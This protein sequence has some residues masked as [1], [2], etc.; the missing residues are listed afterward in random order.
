VSSRSHKTTS[1]I[2]N[3]LLLRPLPVENP[4]GL[5]QIYTGSSHVSYPNFR[6]FEAQSDVFTGVA[7]HR[8][9]EFNMAEGGVPERVSGEFVSGNYFQVLGVQAKVGRVLSLDD[10]RPNAPGVAVISEE[11]WQRRLRSDPDVIGRTIRLNG[12]SCMLRRT[13]PRRLSRIL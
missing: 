8:F 10:D 9:D 5:V 12:H 7:A 3:T 1:S 4:S 13:R 6:D 11:L 2:L